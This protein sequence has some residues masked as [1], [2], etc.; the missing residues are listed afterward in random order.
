MLSSPFLNFTRALWQGGDLSLASK[1]RPSEREINEAMDF[2]MEIETAYRDTL[3]VGLPHVDRV[4]AQWALMSIYRVA[5]FLVFRELPEELMRTELAGKCPTGVGPEVCYSVDLSFRFLPELL[6]LTRAVSSHDPLLD[7][8]RSWASDWPLSSVGM[9][10]IEIGS[11]E[12]I[13]EN[14][15]LSTLYAD[16]IL[17]TNDQS[18]LADP[19]VADIVR[20]ALGGFRE[21]SPVNY[22]HLSGPA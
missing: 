18:R 9:V 21:L 19:H 1:D 11:V 14:R 12:S 16:R 7:V 22:D 3:P 10:G 15:A 2:L 8:L 13:L 17:A 20:T 5:Q 6:R 4:A